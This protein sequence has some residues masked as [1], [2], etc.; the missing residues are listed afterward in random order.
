ML[1]VTGHK[2]YFFMKK[3]FFS[4][5]FAAVV[6][7]FS[8]CAI[9]M[10]VGLVY[11]G[12]TEPVTATANSIGSKVGTAK[13][14]SLFQAFAWGDGSINTAA[15]MAGIKKISHVDVK[16]MSIFGL[17]TTRTYFVYGE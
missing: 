17:Y 11:T 10:T 2:I 16:T 9:P 7:S 15:K 8:S 12:K 14:T 3:V 13:S 4:V 5:A 6:L 1:G